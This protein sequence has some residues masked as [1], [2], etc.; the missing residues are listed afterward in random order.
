MYPTPAQ[1]AV[2]LAQCGQARYV[3]NLALAQWSMW[4]KDWV[5][6]TSTDLTRRETPPRVSSKRE[7]QLTTFARVVVGIPVVHCGEDGKQSQT[8]RRRGWVRGAEVVSAS[9]CGSVCAIGCSAGS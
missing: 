9:V 2:V 4:R 6:K 3:W 1:Q 7:P 8:Q 5:E